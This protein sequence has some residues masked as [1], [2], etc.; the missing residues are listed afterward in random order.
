MMC[1]GMVHKTIV[2]M[3][4]GGQPMLS[5]EQFYISSFPFL[6]AFVVGDLG[7]EFCVFVTGWRHAFRSEWPFIIIIIVGMGMGMGDVVVARLY[8]HTQPHRHLH[9]WVGTGQAVQLYR[10]A[11]QGARKGH[12]LVG[13]WHAQ[14]LCHTHH[15][16]HRLGHH[17]RARGVGCDQ[18]GGACNVLSAQVQWAVSWLVAGLVG[19]LVGWL[20]GLLTWCLLTWCLL[21]LILK[22]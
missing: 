1:G 19:W 6:N 16:G 13:S 15:G 3:E 10:M 12:V 20:V 22:S 17:V 2:G 5:F 14:H 7:F 21:V 8:S 4:G 18:V 11:N 9:G